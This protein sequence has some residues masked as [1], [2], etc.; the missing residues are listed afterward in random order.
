MPRVL[1][2]A[3]GFEEASKLFDGLAEVKLTFDRNGHGLTEEEFTRDLPAYD[4]VIVWTDP[5]TRRAIEAGRGKIKVI[6][7]PRAGCDNVD[8]E[9]ATRFGIPVIYAPGANASAVADHTIGLLL[10]VNRGIARAHHQLKTGLWNGR[11][12]MLPGVGL[13]GRTLGIIGL[14]SVGCRVAMRARAFGMTIIA[15]DSALDQNTMTALG[16]F[17]RELGVRLVDL[18]TL[19]KESDFITIHVPISKDT[20]GMIGSKE[21]SK[22]KNTAYIINTARGGVVDEKALYS[23]LSQGRIAGG[24]LDVFETEPIEM[25]NPL[26]KLDNIVVTPHI[27]WCTYEAMAR[28]NLIVA[29]EVRRILAGETPHLRYVANPE[30]VG[31]PRQSR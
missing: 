10:A 13:D 22:A 21:I 15:F 30:T 1:V 25:S 14:G 17:P 9:A 27:A 20:R 19:L 26:L 6:G 8:L 3:P 7:V 31:P 24:A 28:V 18:D 5:L 4:A 16:L 12:A 23:A 2:T 29:R 11:W